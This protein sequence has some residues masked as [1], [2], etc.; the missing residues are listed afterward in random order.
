MESMVGCPFGRFL[1][2]SG[3]FQG[4]PPLRAT[5]RGSPD[6][7]QPPHPVGEGA[8]IRSD[9]CGRGRIPRASCQGADRI[10]ELCEERGDHVLTFTLGGVKD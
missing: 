9:V 8:R 6:Q 5:P 10:P 4:S 3:W 2:L 1:T 7:G